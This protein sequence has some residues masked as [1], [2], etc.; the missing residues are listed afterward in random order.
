MKKTPLA[1]K[2]VKELVGGYEAEVGKK[3]QAV[4]LEDE[5]LRIIFVNDEQGFFFFEGK[6]IPTLRFLQKKDVLKKI[7]VDMG[8]VKFLINGAD[9]M[10]PG[11]VELDSGIAEG[12]IVVIVDVNNK[13]P[14]AVGAALF[15]TEVIRKMEKGKAARII[16]Y[17]GDEI[18]K[19]ELR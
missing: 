19:R 16:H 12:E 8:A 3:D 4:L 18:W 15:D 13:K 5:K 2:K 17:V 10:R 7:V 6:W 1:P 11:I 9:L 14:I